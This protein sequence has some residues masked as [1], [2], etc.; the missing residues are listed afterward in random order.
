M[1]VRTEVPPRH[2]PQSSGGEHRAPGTEDYAGYGD[3]PGYGGYPGTGYEE[4]YPGA[5]YEEDYPGAGYEED[6]PGAGYGERAAARSAGYDEDDEREVPLPPQP[7][8]AV[9]GDSVKGDKSGRRP[10]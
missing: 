5:G 8:K 2:S 9:Q 10:G 3:E 4:D 6:Y 1:R 7:P